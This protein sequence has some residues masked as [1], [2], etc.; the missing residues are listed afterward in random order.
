[1]EKIAWKKIRDCNIHKCRDNCNNTTKYKLVIQ[2]GVIPKDVSFVRL[3][4]GGKYVE[5]D[6]TRN[7]KKPT[8]MPVA[9]VKA[10]LPHNFYICTIVSPKVEIILLASTFE[11][12]FNKNLTKLP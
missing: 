1:M 6:A 8:N 12:F 2:R 5:I 9:K 4:K 3:K 7:T 11:A 10:R